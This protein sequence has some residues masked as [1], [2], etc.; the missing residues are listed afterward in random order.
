LPQERRIAAGLLGF[1][2]LFALVAQTLLLHRSSTMGGDVEYHRGVG[3]TMSAGSWSGEG[4]ID[5]VISYFGGL[6]PLTFGWA[7]HALGVSFDSLLSVVSWPFVLVLPLALLWLGRRLWPDT[8][9]EPAV[10]AFLGTVGSSLALDDRAIWVYSLLPS[11][12]NLW[13]LFPRDV[14]LVLLI[15]ALGI[16]AGGESTRRT[17]LAGVVAGLAIGVQAQIGVYCVGV[18]IAYRLWRAWPVRA[19]R[20]FIADAAIIGTVA[21]AVSAWW[22]WPRID[23]LVETRRLVL[24]SYPGLASPDA[25]LI[26]VVVALG[27]VGLLAV[28]GVVLALRDRRPAERFAAIWLLALAPLALMGTIAGDIGVMTP[29]RVWFLAAVPLVICAAVAATALIRRGPV[30]L[31]MTIL[32]AVIVIPSA[33]EAWQ[34]RDLVTKLW[35]H[36]PEDDPYAESAWAPAMNELR[37]AMDDRGSV[38]VIA[39]DND[40]LYIWKQSG[41]QPFSFLPSGSVKLGFD[42]ALTTRYSYIRRVLLLEKAV[43]AGLPGVCGLAR[44]TDADFIVMRRDGDL[45]GTHDARPSSSY[46]VDPSDRTTETISRRVGPGLTYLDRSA[47]ELLEIAPGSDMTIEW[48]DRGVRR[49]DVYQDRKRPVPPMRLV[50]RDGTRIV[51]SVRHDGRAYVLRFDTPHGIPPGTHLEANERGRARVSRLIGYE[52]VSRFADLSGPTHGPVVLDPDKY[53]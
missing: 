27:A 29:R 4:P 20:R 22:W 1:T 49:L 9:L 48:S 26:G 32:I 8:V 24:K 51:P 2:F 45:L 18:L 30:P 33:A 17:V 44:R 3:F 12:T 37:S 41:A 11:G 42:P 13:P 39:P 46:R 15:V 6:Y 7:S 16:V 10:F 36:Q 35:V 19:M 23:L 34:T 38:T 5:G 40:A 31:V 21:L 28:P 25:S 50:L 47:T 52:P 14:A 43:A 53:C